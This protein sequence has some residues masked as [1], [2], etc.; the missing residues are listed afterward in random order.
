MT[1]GRKRRSRAC[2]FALL[3]IALEV[4]GCGEGPELIDALQ[5]LVD[6]HPRS[7]ETVAD[8]MA[9]EAR[10]E[11]VAGS[12]ECAGRNV[13][14]CGP[15]GSSWRR[16]AQCTAFEDCVLGRC[17]PSQPVCANDSIAPADANL[18]GWTLVFPL[19][20]SGEHD[21]RKPDVAGL[22]CDG[23]IAVWEHYNQEWLLGNVMARAFNS[24]CSPLGPEFPLSATGSE[25]IWTS[26]VAVLAN[27]RAVAVWSQRDP[28]WPCRPHHV[29]GR[30]FSPGKPPDGVEL[31]LTDPDDP[32]EVYPTVAALKDGGFVV[33]W[34]S[35]MSPYPN[36]V[37][38]RRFDANGVPTCPSF[39][40]DPVP[41]G[42]KDSPVVVGLSNGRFVVLYE[43]WGGA[44]L[45]S[46][47]RG[48]EFDSK[49]TPTKKFVVDQ[50][51]V[52]I[53]EFRLAATLAEPHGLAVAWGL[54]WSS[55]SS[56]SIASLSVDEWQASPAK[57]VY[58]CSLLCY[59]PFP[60]VAAS[61]G[62]D[63]VLMLAWEHESLVHALVLDWGSEDYTS[64]Q[65]GGYQNH[66]RSNPSVAWVEPGMFVAAWQDH[67]GADGDGDGVFAEFFGK[68]GLPLNRCK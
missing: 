12:R 53:N 20:E 45:P 42:S 66:E 38:G 29:H 61:A 16:V 54:D 4:P 37:L 68:D 25:D 48:V 9:V 51:D 36:A 32:H 8:R 57:Q 2:R 56:L 14:A 62:D 59:V 31:E 23:F 46:A 34:E 55:S 19:S 35:H 63:P 47:I 11:C 7:V 60:S 1:D 41:G 5:E 52:G 18:W 27:G 24:Q 10:V 30:V 22:P 28:P 44:N 6:L 40:V 67:E 17:V 49:C 21:Q 39:E 3:L 43:A 15:D 33:A 64:V 26:R 50:F 13:L 58:E 65:V